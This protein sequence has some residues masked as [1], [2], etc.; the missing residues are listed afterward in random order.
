MPKC[1]RRSAGS[2]YAPGAAS[3]STRGIP[4]DR[5]YAI[6]RVLDADRTDGARQG[7]A[8]TALE[9]RGAESVMGPGE[10]LVLGGVPV[11]TALRRLGLAN[12]GPPAPAPPR[13]ANAIA[14]APATFNAANK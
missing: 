14:V 10:L 5:R 3:G 11:D 2:W 7:D 4:Y 12:T 13:P 6:G 1:P 8:P 9:V